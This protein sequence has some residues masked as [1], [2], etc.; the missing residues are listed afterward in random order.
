MLETRRIS[1]ETAKST[2]HRIERSDA[3]YLELFFT[4]ITGVIK[5]ISMN[6]EH[7]TEALENGVPYLEQR[8]GEHAL[9]LLPDID[10]FTMLP[11]GAALPQTARMICD[12]HWPAEPT[13][14]GPRALLR[15]VEKEADQMGFTPLVAVDAD[16]CLLETDADGRP[17]LDRDPS[18][19][20]VGAD[21]A[22][23]VAR[24]RIE[25]L[26]AA[27]AMGIAIS[28]A[29]RDGRIGQHEVRLGYDKPTI[30]AD[31]T[32]TVRRLIKTL[33]RRNG[34]H[35]TFMPKPFGGRRG[36]G[37]RLHQRMTRRADGGD[38][39]H[40]ADHPYGLSPT[41]LSYLAGQMEHASGMAAI[42]APSVNSYKRLAPEDD[43]PLTV[44]WGLFSKRP[45]A[46][47]PGTTNR[48][49]Q[50]ELCAADSTANPYLA[51]AISCRCGLL[52]ISMGSRVAPPSDASTHA[53]PQGKRQ[54]TPS[55]PLSLGQA[56]DAL[57]QDVFIRS[58]LGA[59]LYGR[60]RERLVVEWH[61]YQHQVTDWEHRRYLGH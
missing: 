29:P 54:L 11:P 1:D 60:Y 20:G 51:L 27:E 30:I 24:T 17:L 22:G 10:T 16:Y 4:D 42:L 43:T 46:R 34:L 44:T 31:Q 55:L 12:M 18:S 14:L 58:S 9:L 15:R 7:A 57:A 56:I 36:N 26:V 50:I 40:N 61:A 47:V 59:A 25:T 45:Y 49:A 13:A 2:R 23:R 48:R 37:W 3:R 39:W 52:G 32:V 8:P 33:A 41:G 5:R 53:M 6:A 21:L 19:F 28:I 35:A 38:A